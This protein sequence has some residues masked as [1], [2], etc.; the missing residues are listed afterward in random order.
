[1]SVVLTETSENAFIYFR[2]SELLKFGFKTRMSR[3]KSLHS[4]SSSHKIVN[5]TEVR[6]R[7]G[8]QKLDAYSCASRQ[9]A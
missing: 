1:M 5:S 2:S 6:V 4:N 7:T 8:G 3:L 9:I